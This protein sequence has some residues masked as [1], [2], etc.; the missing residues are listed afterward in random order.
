MDLHKALYRL[1]G[2]ATW[3]EESIRTVEGLRWHNQMAAGTKVVAGEL[4]A[5]LR[6]E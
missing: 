3:H 6:A 5:R 1:R 4:F 2:A